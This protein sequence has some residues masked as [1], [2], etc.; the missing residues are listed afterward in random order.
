MFNVLAYNNF[1]STKKRITF[2]VEIKVFKIYYSFLNHTFS[3]PDLYCQSRWTFRKFLRNHIWWNALLK[4]I[5]TL[6]NVTYFSKLSHGYFSPN[7][8]KC[9]EQ[10]SL[11]PS[12]SYIVHEKIKACEIWQHDFLYRNLISLSE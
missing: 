4:N 9:S 8:T 1:K 6:R 5:K 11:T 3:G 7:V 10:L 2:N 12:S